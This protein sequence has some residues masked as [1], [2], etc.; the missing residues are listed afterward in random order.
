MQ[1]ASPCTSLGHDTLPTESGATAAAGSTRTSA[2]L[3]N[4]ALQSWALAAAFLCGA[5]I[6]IQ[7]R[8]NGRLSE[9][10]GSFPA[11][12]F[13]FGSGL[14]V[15]TLLLFSKA[16]RVRVGRVVSALRTRELVWWQMLGGVAGGL[17][18]GSQTYAVPIIGVAAFL[19]ATIGG[20]TVCA[21][22]VDRYGL[23]PAPAQALS[24]LRVLAAGLAVVGVAVAAT[25]G[26]SGASAALFPVLL[27]FLVGMGVAVQQAIN[28]RVNKVSGSA[29]ATTWFN[30]VTGSTTLVVIGI[31]P[32]LRSG[33]PDTWS[34]VPWWAW[35]G[36]LIGVVFIALAAWAV[37]HSGVLLFGLTTITSQMLVALVLD[38]VNPATRD[39]VGL[40]M[41][42]G[43][44][45]T[46]VAAIAAA[47][48]ARRAK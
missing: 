28:G 36:G 13:S 17:L 14:V 4:S 10:V 6:A 45:I 40:Q 8:M 30:F 5:L 47:L 42:I 48:A 34:Q 27:G 11:A 23:G 44:V 26:E 18:V 9:A 7:S 12:W 33:W 21:L 22:F 31:V 19:I 1:P 24:V 16:Q 25:S 38:F 2:V 41:I 39:Q 15:L 43:V 35:W 46:V 32:V 29:L 20:Q 3:S 37:Q